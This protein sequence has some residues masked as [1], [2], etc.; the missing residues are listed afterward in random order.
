MSHVRGFTCSGVA[1][2]ALLGVKTITF[3]SLKATLDRVRTAGDSNDAG[4]AYHQNYVEGQI[5]VVFHWNASLRSAMLARARLGEAGLDTFTSTK[6]GYC[7]YSGP[8]FIAEVGEQAFGSDGEPEFTIL[9]EP[10][11]EWTYAT[12]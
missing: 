1:L 11:T 12:A 5:S 8:A 4:R 10:Q 2:G 9:L 7:T 3:P 6:T